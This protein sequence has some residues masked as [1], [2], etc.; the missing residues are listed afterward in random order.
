MKLFL[1][2]YDMDILPLERKTDS[3][4]SWWQV[5]SAHR[6]VTPYASRISTHGHVPGGQLGTHSG[7]GH[8]EC[9]GMSLF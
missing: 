3:Y 4:A 1:S 6:S 2:S 8:A 5:N 9:L 7:F